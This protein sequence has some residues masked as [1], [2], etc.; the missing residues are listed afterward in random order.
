MM[1][2][3]LRSSF[4]QAM[5]LLFCGLLPV[6]PVL[7]QVKLPRL[8]S[9]GMVLQRG[10]DIKAWGWAGPGEKITVKFD[11]ETE[12]TVTGDDGRWSVTLKP[13]RAGGPYILD[14]TGINRVTVKNILVGDVW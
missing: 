12:N 5:T 6:F 8:I 14:V 4:L 11:G 9:D 2:K 7:A 13:R 10:V 3:C 1:K